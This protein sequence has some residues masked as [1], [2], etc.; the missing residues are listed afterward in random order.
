M[1]LVAEDVT[2]RYGGRAALSG[3]SFAAR[4][5]ERVAVIGPNGAGKTTLLSVLAGLVAP[6]SGRIDAAGAAVGWVP[7]QPAVYRKLSVAENLR[8]FARLERVPDVGAAVDEAL[9]RTGL[10]DRPAT[11]S[12]PSPAAT[13]SG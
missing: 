10:A 1:S 13:S 7:Q 12:A 2:K 8:L 4:P 6:T 11:S 9:A 5:G 3:V